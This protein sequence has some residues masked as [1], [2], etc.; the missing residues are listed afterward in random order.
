MIRLVGPGGA[1]KSTIGAL[2]AERLNVAFLDLDRHFADRFGDIGEYIDRHGYDAYAQ[3]NVETYCSLACAE[4]ASDVVALSSGFMTYAHDIQP[5]Y[6]TVRSE[7]AESPA[8]FVLLP[9]LDRE[10]C[11]TE[12][13]RRQ[14][15]RPFGRSAIREEA[16]IRA[17]FEIYMAVPA[18]KIETMRPVAAA[19]D[20]IIASLRPKE[21]TM[22]Y[23]GHSTCL[24]WPAMS[25]PSA[26]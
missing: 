16:V 2:L 6:P 9:S 25:E 10:V 20:E 15:G 17:R 1:G 7:I 8:T 4:T 23:S 24:G 22:A 19:V 13:V 3:A 18:R 14:I 11:V 26:R 21:A 12:A 5:E